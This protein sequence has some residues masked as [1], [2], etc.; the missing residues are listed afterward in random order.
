MIVAEIATFSIP[1]VLS[2]QQNTAWNA[3]AKEAAATISQAYLLYSAKNSITANTTA[4]AFTPYMNYVK[5]DTS[6]QIDHFTGGGGITC[7]SWNYCIVLHNGG[8]LQYDTGNYFGGTNT[9]NYVYF[10]FDPDGKYSGSTTGPGKSITLDLY[11]NGRVI[12]AANKLA[13]ATTTDGGGVHAWGA[14]ATASWF[15]W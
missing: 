1:K 11:T 8:V 7:N 13:G 4:G 10:R 5:V 15:S 3:A 14:E 2:A 12:D 9:N 6:S